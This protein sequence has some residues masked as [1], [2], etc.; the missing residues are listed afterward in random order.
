V[1]IKSDN[2]K[3]IL[4]FMAARNCKNLKGDLMARKLEA[5]EAKECNIV[6]R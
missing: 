1:I 2:E 5:I 4:G 6:K 3:V